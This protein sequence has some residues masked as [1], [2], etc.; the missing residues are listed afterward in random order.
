MSFAVDEVDAFQVAVDL[1]GDPGPQEPCFDRVVVGAV[2]SVFFKTD[3]IKFAT[4]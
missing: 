4:V 3:G 1:W 2:K